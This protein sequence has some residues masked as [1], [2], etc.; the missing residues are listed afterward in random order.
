MKWCLAVREYNFPTF[1]LNAFTVVGIFS[2]EENEKTKQ[3][4]IIILHS[5][6]SF[7]FVFVYNR[8]TFLFFSFCFLFLFF[9][10]LF[11]FLRLSFIHCS[12]QLNWSSG[13]LIF[14]NF[15]WVCLLNKIGSWGINASLLKEI[16]LEKWDQNSDK[17]RFL[18]KLFHGVMML[19]FAVFL[20]WK[21]R[22]CDLI[23]DSSNQWANRRSQGL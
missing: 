19:L 16:K 17:S 7:L 10:F 12:V 20:Q 18:S 1:F 11:F 5:F 8:R 2:V 14:L 9:F 23:V 6:K 13:Y 4:I 22:I 15:N 21:W 3:E